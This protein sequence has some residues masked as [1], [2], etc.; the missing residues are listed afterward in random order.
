VADALLGG[1]GA[2]GAAML[3]SMSDEELLS[4]VSLDLGRATAE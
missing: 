2:D 4:A 3:T 1:G